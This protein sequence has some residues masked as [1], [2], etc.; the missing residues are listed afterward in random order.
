M[1]TTPGVNC[2]EGKMTQTQRYCPV[3]CN[4]SLD[5][6]LG[7]H[8]MSKQFA[9]KIESVIESFTMWIL[10]LILINDFI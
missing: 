8:T 1:N 2:F 7:L 3:I 4:Y 10:I 6:D 9:R 5:L